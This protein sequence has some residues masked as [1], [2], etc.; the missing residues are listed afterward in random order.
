MNISVI[1]PNLSMSNQNIQWF[2]G[3][4]NK[5]S[6]ELRKV[7]AQVNVFVE[8]RDARVPFS[9]ANPMLAEMRGEKP[10]LVVLTKTDLSDPALNKRWTDHF[11]AQQNTE[12]LMVDARNRNSVSRISKICRT[13]Y[14]KNGGKQPRTTAL[15][16]GIP[17]VGKSTLINSLA[18]RSVAKTGNEPAIT[19][20]QQ[21]IDINDNF[22]LMD[23][24]GLMWPK[25][26]N[27][28]SGFRLAVTGAIKDTA[29]T[30]L[31]VA[32][33]AL[34]YL[35]SQYIEKL[36]GRYKLNDGN[37]ENLSAEFELLEEIGR[38]RGCLVKGGE[39]DL[40]RAA[41]I[42]LADLRD[43]RTGRITWESPEMMKMEW[44]EVEQQR[45]QTC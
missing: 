31:E 41:K 8:L 40:D 6:K 20:H 3:H 43:G 7:Y 5:A 4:M 18:G 10:C 11:L 12:V 44:Q 17:N 1:Q 30:H 33:F 15:V 35:R 28:N 23:T 32:V 45:E 37:V 19:K 25:V 24:P 38:R 42:V 39:I 26:Q 2:P 13:L 22:T 9:S 27:R 29:I 14:E 21:L 34:E 16:M 36:C